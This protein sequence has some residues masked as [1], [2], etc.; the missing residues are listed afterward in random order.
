MGGDFAKGLEMI[1]VGRAWWDSPVGAAYVDGIIAFLSN[2]RPGL[3]A[4]R[5]RMIAIPPPSNWAHTQ[6]L[7]RKQAGWVPNWPE[8]IDAVDKMIECWGKGYTGGATGDCEWSPAKRP[9]TR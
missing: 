1:E 5:E 7:Y 6:E 4:A 8:N 3:M 9:K 2:D